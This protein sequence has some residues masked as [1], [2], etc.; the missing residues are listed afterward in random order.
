[1]RTPETWRVVNWRERAHAIKRARAQDYVGTVLLPGG[2][3]SIC[4]GVGLGLRLGIERSHG[5][6]RCRGELGPCLCAG[7]QG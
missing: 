1:M 6:D 7:S 3:Y 2:S 4:C 5:S